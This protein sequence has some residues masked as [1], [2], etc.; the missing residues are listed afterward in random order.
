ML[1]AFR[2]AV[3]ASLLSSFPA[4]AADSGRIYI[5]A[6]RSTAAHSW[7]AIACDDVVLAKVKRGFFFAF[8]APPGHHTLSVKN[9]VPAIVDVRSNVDSY[10]RLDW[11]MEVGRPPVPV[12][13]TIA[14]P[15]ARS[16][17]RF[18]SYVDSRHIDA[19]SVL[20]T[21]PRPPE[22]NELLKRDSTPAQPNQ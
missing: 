22:T 18:L 14:P 15:S 6:Q 5:Y 16:E 8:D 3:S 11:S 20:R 13:S 9:G 1:L 19:A 10:L 12:L 17:M 4:L 2:I 7:L 21:D